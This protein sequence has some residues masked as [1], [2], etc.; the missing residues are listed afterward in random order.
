MA[1]SNQ[2]EFLTFFDPRQVNF[3]NSI[4][5][6]LRLAEIVRPRQMTLPSLLVSSNPLLKFSKLNWQERPI[7][8]HI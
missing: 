8:V 1:L 7:T 4:I 5:F 3:K 6:G 2:T